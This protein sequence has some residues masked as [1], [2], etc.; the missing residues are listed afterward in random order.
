MLQM[1]FMMMFIRSNSRKS[2]RQ[3]WWKSPR[4]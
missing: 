4:T 3:I 1:Y 2:G